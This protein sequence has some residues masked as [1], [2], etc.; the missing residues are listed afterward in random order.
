MSDASRTAP[1]SRIRWRNLLTLG[2]LTV[3]VGTEVMGAAIAG[4][5]ALAGLL[6]LGSMLEYAFMVLFGAMGLW[7]MVAFV[8]R[9]LKV[10]P[11]F[12]P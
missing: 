1:S 11:I 4:G 3:L 9:G 2:S 10:E 12:A 5:W 8:R 7:G 6:G